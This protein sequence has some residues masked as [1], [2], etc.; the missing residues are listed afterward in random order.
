VVYSKAEGPAKELEAGDVIVEIERT[1]IKSISDVADVL[2]AS[3]KVFRFKV[4]RGQMVRTARI[5][6][7]TNPVLED[8]KSI[9]IEGNKIKN[10]PPINLIAN[11]PEGKD[12]LTKEICGAFKEDMESIGI[13]VSIDYLDGNAY[14]SRLQKGDFDLAFRNV[15]VTGTPSLYLMFYKNPNQEN[16]TNTNYGSYFNPQINEMAESIRNVTD[17]EVVIDAWKKAH[18]VLN[19]DPPYIFLWSRKHIVIYND[20]L[21]IIAPNPEYKVPHGYKQIDGKINVFNEIH[22]WGMKKK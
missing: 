17:I 3:D 5:Q 2:S 14:Y 8:L 9:A 12:T 19:I 10:F 15:K 13:S 11:N 18:K 7:G 21:Q 6:R 1:P 20:R 16:I 22:L 4:I